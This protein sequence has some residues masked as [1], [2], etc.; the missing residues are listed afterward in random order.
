MLKNQE[1]Y[2]ESLLAAIKDM[3]VADHIIYV[4]YPIVKD[5]QLLLKALDLVYESITN[6]INSTL[7]YDYMWKRIQ[8]YKDVRTNFGTFMDKCSKRLYLAQEELA[9][10]RELFSL[11]ESHR[12]SPMEFARGSKVIIMS[13]NLKT[14]F[15][16][17]EKLKKYLNLS[18]IAIE[19]A[20]RYMNIA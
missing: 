6:I 20:K 11:I 3:K 19:K 9:E 18:R 7:Q 14:S 16:D 5:K 4:T 13:N 8:L 2:Q 1:K 10:I 12:K 15:L 17:I